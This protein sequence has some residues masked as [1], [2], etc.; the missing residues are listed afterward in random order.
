MLTDPD[1][2]VFA[3][4]PAPIVSQPVEEPIVA[5][6]P[7]PPLSAPT[8]PVTT[9]P[10]SYKGAH[11]IRDSQPVLTAAATEAPATIAGTNEAPVDF[12]A[13]NLQHDDATRVITATGNVQLIQSGKI[14]RAQKVV[15]DLVNEKAHAEGNVV[16]SDSNGDVYFADR[17]ELTGQM[18]EGVASKVQ[19]YLGQGGRFTGAS[20]L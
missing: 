9:P 1:V 15:Y 2:E 5:A 19:A 18:R 7:S 16:L 10:A 8:S 12:E 3:L 14:L 6:V 20:E 13:D 11:E 17:V 4:D